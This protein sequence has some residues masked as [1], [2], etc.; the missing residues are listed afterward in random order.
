[1]QYLTNH[2]NSKAGVI[3]IIHAEE[4]KYWTKGLRQAELLIRE[5][6]KA[7]E[8][9]RRALIEAKAHMD[10]VQE[11]LIYL[12]PLARFFVRIPI[13]GTWFN[14]KVEKLS[15]LITQYLDSVSE[16]SLFR[17]CEL[18]L[19]TAVKERDRIVDEHPEARLLSFEELEERYGAIALLEQKVAYLAPRVFAAERGLPVE[20]AVVLFETAPEERHYLLERILEE[21]EGLV[22]TEDSVALIGAIATASP[23]KQHQI[24]SLIGG[25]LEQE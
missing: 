24:L 6:D 7:L 14:N 2:S 3:D 18:E 21:K 23:E 9:N 1:M 17:D 20:V 25:D 5:K 12:R 10:L 11:T 16:T 22:L 13:I 4:R 19:A 8:T 15:G